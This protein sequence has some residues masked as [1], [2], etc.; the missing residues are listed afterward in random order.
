LISIFWRNSGRSFAAAAVSA[1]FGDLVILAS[2]VLGLAVYTHASLGSVFAV[3]FAPFLPGE[4][5][6]I[7]AVAA[8]ALG[9]QRFRRNPA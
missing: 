9:V 4:A 2:G 7:I 5:L 1:A 8:I 3:G 6:K